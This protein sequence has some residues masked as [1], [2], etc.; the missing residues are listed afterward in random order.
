M[1]FLSQ[2]DNLDDHHQINIP[3]QVKAKKDSTADLLTMFMEHCQVKFKQR[4][5]SFDVLKG[6]WCVE[7]R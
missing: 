4:D 5:G 1:L 7:C 3:V 6:R 2:E